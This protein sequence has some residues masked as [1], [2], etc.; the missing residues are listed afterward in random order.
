VAE[1]SVDPASITLNEP[2][3]LLDRLAELRLAFT[4]LAEQ[5]RPPFHRTPPT[6]VIPAE[7]GI[8]ADIAI[9]QT[10]HGFPPSRERRASAAW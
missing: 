4:L 3:N 10:R 5:D 6:N 9:T 2:L 7:A 8:Y 1:T